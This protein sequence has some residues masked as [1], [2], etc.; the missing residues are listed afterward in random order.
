MEAVTVV[1]RFRGAETGDTDF[2]EWSLTENTIKHNEKPNKKLKI[3][4]RF[5]NWDD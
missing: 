3:K 4:T 5:Q 1:A 2:G